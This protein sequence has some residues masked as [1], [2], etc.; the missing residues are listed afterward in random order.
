MNSNSENALQPQEPISLTAFIS[1]C[2]IHKRGWKL[3]WAKKKGETSGES[4]SEMLFII[5]GF[6]AACWWRKFTIRIFHYRDT[7]WIAVWIEN[8]TPLWCLWYVFDC[9]L[10]Q[11]E[12]FR[13]FMDVTRDSLT[14]T[15][16]W[17]WVNLRAFTIAGLK[18]TFYE[19]KDFT[20][21]RPGSFSC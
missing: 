17:R 16:N 18:S 14:T 9:I 13:L 6:R 19:G 15:G 10:K 11:K 5:S 20:E 1:N 8:M 21:S 3:M 12:Y 2:F 4:Y 7:L